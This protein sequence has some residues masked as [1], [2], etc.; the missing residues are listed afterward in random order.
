MGHD[1]DRDGLP[2]LP[3]L[4]D[5]RRDTDAMVPQHA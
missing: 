4:L 2:F 1:H 5:D 3:S